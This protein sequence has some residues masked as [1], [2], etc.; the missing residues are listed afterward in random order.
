M[1]RD[2]L[3]SV[4][5][6]VGTLLDFVIDQDRRGLLSETSTLPSYAEL[7]RRHNAK[8]RPSAQPVNCPE[9]GK[10]LSCRGNLTRHLKTA[11]LGRRVYCPVPYCGVSFGQKHDLRRHMKRKHN[12]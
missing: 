12:R 7:L 11:H 10:L 4:R 5:A 6:E 1:P 2:S 3:Q 9:C 8:S